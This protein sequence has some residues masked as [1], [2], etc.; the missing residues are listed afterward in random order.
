MEILLWLACG[1]TPES[2]APFRF[3]PRALRAVT[4]RLHAVYRGVICLILGG[5]TRDFHTQTV[6]TGQLMTEEGI[7][8]HHLFPVV[9]LDRRGVAPARTRECVLNRTLIDRTSNR[10]ISNRTPS[11]Y[12]AEM[13]IMPRFPFGAVLASNGLPAGSN[14]PLAGNDH[15]AFLVWWE[16]HLWR[17]IRR[18]SGVS[19]VTD[20][21]ADAKDPE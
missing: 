14:S 2:I 21:E 17:E 3:N 9:Y 8:A 5:G 11:D 12:L 6:I 1:D 19:V 7:D 18:V 4:P 16:Q 20:L 15:E 13:R 10:I